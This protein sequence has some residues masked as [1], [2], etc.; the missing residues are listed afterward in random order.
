MFS[1]LNN[2]KFDIAITLSCSQYWGPVEM[3]DNYS[4]SFHM[5]SVHL[6]GSLAADGWQQQHLDNFGSQ[7]L[8]NELLARKSIHNYFTIQ[9]AAESFKKKYLLTMCDALSRANIV[10]VSETA[11]LSLLNILA[12]V[13]KPRDFNLMSPKVA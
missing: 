10:G 11:P 5:Q 9:S 7:H 3:Q 2:W 12:N 6:L 1:Y 4:E 8:E 13:F